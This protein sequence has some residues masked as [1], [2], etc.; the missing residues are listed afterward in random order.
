MQCN[1]MQ[2]S[3]APPEQVCDGYSEYPYSESPCDE[4]SEY[5]R[6]R[7]VMDDSSFEAHSEAVTK[8]I[9]AFVTLMA[10]LQARYAVDAVG[11]P[12]T[13]NHRSIHS[14]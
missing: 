10:P 12:S 4:C 8:F 1:A 14:L 5:H 7:Y 9:D 13:R 2:C 11:R 3:S 6:R